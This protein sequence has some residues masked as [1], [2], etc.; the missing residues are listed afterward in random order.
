MDS[1]FIKKLLEIR[2]AALLP[3]TVTLENGTTITGTVAFVN[4]NAVGISLPT[5][6]Q[7][8]K[9]SSILIVE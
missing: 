9:I 1:S 8:V 5:G 7:V 6:L 2:A 3:V 4:D